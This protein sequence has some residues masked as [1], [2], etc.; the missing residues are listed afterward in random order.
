MSGSLPADPWV[1]EVGSG[2]HGLIFHFPIGRRIGID[3]VAADYVTLFPAW[4]RAAQTCAAF[5]EFL[6]FRRASFDV[7]LC[8]NVVDHA[9]FPGRIVG[10]IARVLKP[11]GL[12]YF[13]VNVHHPIYHAASVLHGVWKAT[14]ARFELSAFSD[15][16]VHLTIDKARGLFDGLPLDVVS[17][18]YDVEAA[19]RAAR[20]GRPRHAGDRLKR[21][22][23]KNV[24]FERVAVRRPA[25]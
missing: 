16:T 18:R 2:A 21:Y 8:D 11:G 22:F 19:R 25:S 9:E 20:A 23:Y 3:P 4:Q 10:E 7:V 1:L 13:T 17:E 6:P 24:L 14:G 12:L 5:G 15:H